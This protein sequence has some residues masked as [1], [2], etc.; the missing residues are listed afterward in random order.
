MLSLTVGAG[1]T[2]LREH[3]SPRMRKTMPAICGIALS[4][5]F[6][7]R[8]LFAQASTPAPAAIS[9]EDDR[10]SRRQP[11]RRPGP[12]TE[13][14]FSGVDR[15]ENSRGRFALRSRERRLERRYQRRRAPADRLDAPAA[16][17]RARDRS[18]RQRRFARSA[19][20]IAQGKPPGDY[21]QGEGEESVGQDCD[22]GNAD[23]AKP[24]RGLRG[25]FRSAFTPTSREKITPP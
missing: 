1:S 14:G 3:D 12:A 16:D 11:D 8:T 15:R 2:C 20:K 18:W 23:A 22:R 24:G 5:C 21:R 25:G 10:F 19:G 17:R 7:S 4:L 6:F 9:N 13:R